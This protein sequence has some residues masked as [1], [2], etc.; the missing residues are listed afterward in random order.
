MPVESLLGSSNKQTSVFWFW[1]SR[2]FALFC[3]IC[4]L[5]A[6]LYVL[7]ILLTTTIKFNELQTKVE[8]QP[9][10]AE[11]VEIATKI[12][13]KFIDQNDNDNYKFDDT[14][15][16]SEYEI[17]KIVTTKKVSQQLVKAMY[18]NPELAFKSLKSD[19]Y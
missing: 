17:S 10:T 7:I 15:L 9:T 8:H 12:D 14:T 6:I 18:F 1:F 3:I 13:T 19:D 5:S 2:L 16:A 4:L 11:Y